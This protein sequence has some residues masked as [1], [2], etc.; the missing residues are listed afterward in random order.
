M[1]SDWERRLLFNK[2][3]R[4]MSWPGS[5]GIV[6]HRRLTSTWCWDQ[7]VTYISSS[8]SMRPTWMLQGLSWC[9][10]GIGRGL[11]HFKSHCC[12][13]TRLPGMTVRSCPTCL[14]L[15]GVNRRLSR[16]GIAGLGNR[17]RISRSAFALFS[18]TPGT[19]SRADQIRYFGRLRQLSHSA[20]SAFCETRKCTMHACNTES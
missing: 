10:E 4:R 5:G 19:D 12:F 6:E 1:A 18:Q 20:L 16:R 3:G 11:L 15:L 17:P 2:N 7:A 14:C 8:L 9:K 13:W